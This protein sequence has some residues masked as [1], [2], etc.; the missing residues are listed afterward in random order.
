[1]H[2]HR[3]L[4]ARMGAWS[5]AHRKRAVL[6]W[7]AFVVIAFAVGGAVGLKTLDPI[8][9]ENGSSYVADQAIDKAGFVEN[10]NEQVLVQGRGGVRFG[11]PEIN[12]GVRD[13]ITRLEAIRAVQKIK[14]PL[15]V[16]NDGQVSKDGR[17]ALVTFEIKGDLD[18]AEHRVDATIAAV[19]AA[20]RA[21]RGVRIE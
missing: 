9:T 19:A 14:S 11:D 15:D 5:A 7:I 4:A 6:G 2:H 21:N 13:V 1:M 12:A 20:Q 3:N 10:V 16:G 17:S 8:D 18:K